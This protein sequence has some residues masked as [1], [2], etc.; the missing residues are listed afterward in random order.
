MSYDNNQNAAPA[1]ERKRTPFDEFR[2]RLNAKPLQQGAKSPSL[3]FDVYQNNANFRVYTNIEGQKPIYAGMDLYSFMAVL[4][5]L[6][7]FAADQMGDVTH[8]EVVCKTGSP[9]DMKVA[10]KV[11]VGKD[12]Q[13]AIFISV[14]A[15]NYPP[16][17]FVFGPSQYHDIIDHQGNPC[18]IDEISR[19]FANVF[20]NTATK[21]VL[22]H[23]AVNPSQEKPSFGGADGEKKPWQGGNGGKKPWQGNNGGGGQK[24]WQKKPWQGNN[25]GGGNKQ[26]QGKKQWNN[27]NQQQSSQP[28]QQSGGQDNWDDSFPM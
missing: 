21:L 26:W 14:L 1:A 3:K 9:R 19:V 22:T 10:C 25:N 6:S 5:Y 12:E 4:N 20:A 8:R 17:K 28:Q 27:N 13:N 24:P 11:R 15:E 18:G 16:I 2:L 7:K 23:L